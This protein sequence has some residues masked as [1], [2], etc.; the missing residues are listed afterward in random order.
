[1]HGRRHA[2]VLQRDSMH[3]L[4]SIC[5]HLLTLHTYTTG[6]LTS[7]T[8]PKKHFCIPIPTFITL[9]WPFLLVHMLVGNWCIRFRQCRHCCHRVP[10]GL[11]GDRLLGEGIHTPSGPHCEAP[12]PGLH[13][14]S[15][16][17]NVQRWT[18]IWGELMIRQCRVLEASVAAL[19]TTGSRNSISIWGTGSHT[20][21]HKNTL[22]NVSNWW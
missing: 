19:P 10:R 14:R 18:H 12:A 13:L 16:L 17:A 4:S 2:C 3:A 22:S 7:K 20:N 8:P 1:M 5:S 9:S 6:T 21:T 15:P 11:S